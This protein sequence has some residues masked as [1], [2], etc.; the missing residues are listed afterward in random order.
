MEK[1]TPPQAKDRLQHLKSI[2]KI[3][4]KKWGVKT[5]YKA[6]EVL[7]AC[8]ENK[9]FPSIPYQ[10]ALSVFCYAGTFTKHYDAIGEHHSYQDCRKIILKGIFKSDSE[11]WMKSKALNPEQGKGSDRSIGAMIFEWIIELPFAILEGLSGM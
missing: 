8:K 2:A 9:A 4:T 3:L 7:L 10:Y 11:N 6:D 1:L 5:N